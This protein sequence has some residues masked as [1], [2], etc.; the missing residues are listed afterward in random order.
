MARKAKQ[1]ETGTA[2]FDANLERLKSIVETMEKGDLNLEESLKLFE[3]GIGLSCS[4]FETLSSSE[5][6]VEELLATME[7]MSFGKPEE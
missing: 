6:K 2:R 3:E 7:K 4:L 5:G 1:E